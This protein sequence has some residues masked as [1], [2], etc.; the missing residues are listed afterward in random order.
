MIVLINQPKR[1]SNCHSNL[2]IQSHFQS[3]TKKGKIEFFRD[4]PLMQP[5]TFQSF[6]QNIHTFYH[7]SISENTGFFK[8][9]LDKRL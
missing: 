8:E 9:N 7:C 3:F 4:C 1:L 5:K 2:I 6:R